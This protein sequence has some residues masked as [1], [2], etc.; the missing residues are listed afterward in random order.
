MVTWNSMHQKVLLMVHDEVR[1]KFP[2][3]RRG[4]FTEWYRGLGE[5]LCAKLLRKKLREIIR[6]YSSTIESVRTEYERDM[7]LER[8]G[9]ELAVTTTTVLVPMLWVTAKTLL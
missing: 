1:A 2:F 8:L 9:G 7:V 6:A 5:D 3:W 4:K